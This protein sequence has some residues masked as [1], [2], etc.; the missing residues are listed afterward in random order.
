MERLGVIDLGTNTFHLLIVKANESGRFEELER[1][2]VFIKLAEE[3]IKTIGDAP[4]ARGIKAIQEFRDILKKYDV[5]RV[6][7]F[8]TAALRT[9]SNGQAFL[10]QVKEQ[11]GVNVQLITGS[12]EAGY[13]YRGVAQA[14]PLGEEKSLIMDIGGGSVEFILANN[15]TVFW[16]QSFPIGVAVLY[17]RFHRSDPI[18]LG[19]IEEINLFLQQSLHPLLK[20]LSSENSLK[21]IG[22]SGTFDVLQNSLATHTPDPFHAFVDSN[23]FHP[24]YQSILHTTLAERRAMKEIPRDRVDMIV[25]AL[26]LIDFILQKT[27]IHQIIISAYSLKEGILHEMIHDV[28][29]G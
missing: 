6:K 15:N 13:I 28:T 17:K 20:V 9:A 8:G 18:T 26:I 22:A 3:G 7:A 1:V 29:R 19:E 4:Y 23:D 24:F 2:R 21:L 5:K 25:V 10:R 11:T 16:K 12:I 14:V 27:N